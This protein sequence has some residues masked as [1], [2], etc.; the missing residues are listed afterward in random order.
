ME[1]RRKLQRAVEAIP[2]PLRDA[3]VMLF[4]CGLTYEQA[5]RRVGCGTDTVYYR[6]HKAHAWLRDVMGDEAD[7]FWN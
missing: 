1:R 4:V 7:S 5:G 2:Q 3:F 6:A